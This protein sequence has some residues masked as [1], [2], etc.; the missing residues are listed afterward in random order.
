MEQIL[1]VGVDSTQYSNGSYKDGC[2]KELCS[3]VF[4]T[5]PESVRHKKCKE[6]RDLSILEM[7]LENKNSASITLD[8]EN[9]PDNTRPII[10]SAAK[11]TSFYIENIF[12]QQV[13][14]IQVHIDGPLYGKEKSHLKNILKTYGKVKVEGY[15]KFVK[16]K[17]T[18]NHSTQPQIVLAADA[19]SNYLFRR[20]GLQLF[21]K[22]DSRTSVIIKVP[23]QRMLFEH[24]HL[25]H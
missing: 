8:S 24:I 3:A 18:E 22:I 10:C 19:L 6:K 7:F 11:L 21:P 9:M 1:Y 17:K 20:K 4:S 16:T 25:F 2:T 14:E 23:F 13:E 12:K 5:N 15:K